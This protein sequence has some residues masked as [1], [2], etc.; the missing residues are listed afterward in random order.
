[1]SQGK[2]ISER[3]QEAIHK[4]YHYLDGELT[5]QK[6]KIIEQH[7]NEC[8]PCEEAFGFEKELRRV[9]A[10]RLKE[11]VPQGLKEKIAKLIEHELHEN[12]SS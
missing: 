2:F 9:I 7:L 5:E 8:H 6:R 3:C 12:S 1:M 4:L 10:N 11:E